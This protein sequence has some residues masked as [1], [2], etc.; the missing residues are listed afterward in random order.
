M[1]YHATGRGVISIPSIY[2]KKLSLKVRMMLNNT[3]AMRGGSWS[4]GIKTDHWYAWVDSKSLI[5]ACKENNLEKI[6]GCWG[7]DCVNTE[8]DIYQVFYDSKSGQESLFLKEISPFV[9]NGII[10]W[11]GEDGSKWKNVFKQ[12]QMKVF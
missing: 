10:E 7:F 6:F 2:R 8:E 5:S 9:V 1:G 4:N 11:V 3:E 12:G